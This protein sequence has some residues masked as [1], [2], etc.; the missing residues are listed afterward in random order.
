MF[1][2]LTVDSNFVSSVGASERLRNG[3]GIHGVR[4]RCC[5]VNGTAA[6]HVGLKLAGVGQGDEVISQALTFIATCNFIS[7]CGAVSIY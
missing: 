1:C 2:W 6:L 5:T 7:Y 3:R 4:V